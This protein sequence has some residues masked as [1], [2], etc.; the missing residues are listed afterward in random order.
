MMLRDYKEKF[1]LLPL[2]HIVWK[3][4][5]ESKQMMQCVR[6]TENILIAHCVVS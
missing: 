2:S 3:V 6:S 5:A 4:A 1:S